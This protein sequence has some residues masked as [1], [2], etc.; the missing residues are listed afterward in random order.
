MVLCPL[1]CVL[2]FLKYT[3]L[4]ITLIVSTIDYLASQ[5]SQGAGVEP[6]LTI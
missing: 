5:Q 2:P 1:N 6:S 4:E 3:S